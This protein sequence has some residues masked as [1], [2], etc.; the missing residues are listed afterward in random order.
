MAVT[1]TVLQ[2]FGTIQV[3][4]LFWKIMVRNSPI[5]V[6]ISLR[7]LAGSKSGPEALLGFSL[8]RS[9]TTPS[10]VTSV[11]GIDGNGVPSGDGMLLLSSLVHVDSY[12]LLRIS[13][14]SFGSACSRP[15]SLRGAMPLESFRR[16]LIKD[17]N[18]FCLGL[19]SCQESIQ[20]SIV[21][22]ANRDWACQT[23]RCHTLSNKTSLQ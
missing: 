13:A 22:P 18:R 5:S 19:C 4:K 10:L 17:Q 2:S 9:F 11:S 20:S 3:S 23:E 16:D 7:T 6:A 8:S 15:F 1:L 21:R 14:L 12:C